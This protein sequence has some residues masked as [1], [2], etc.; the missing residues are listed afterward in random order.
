MTPT[1]QAP[2]SD[3]RRNP[4]ISQDALDTL[5]LRGRTFY[6]FLDRPIP[7]DVLMRLYDLAKMGPTSGNSSPMRVL[8]LTSHEAKSRLATHLHGSNKEKSLSAPAVAI[9]A[10]DTKF[11][12]QLHKLNPAQDAKSW[13][14]D[15][16]VAFDTAFRNS[17]LQ[18]AYLLLA[19]RALGLDAG[20]MSG[21]DKDGVNKEFFPEGDW[22]VNFLINLGYGDEEKTYPRQGRLSFE[23]AA[24][25][26]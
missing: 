13:F 2:T 7:E 23:E 19:A 15:P 25:I 12:D 5:F 20:P 21:F 3:W 9:I 24:K 1:D 6:G 18:G 16:A 17:S 14:T 11:F 26:L 10:W 8:F 22:T 4:P